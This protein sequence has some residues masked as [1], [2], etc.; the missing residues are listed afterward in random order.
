MS[1]IG[2]AIKSA[3]NSTVARLASQWNARPAVNR[4]P[5][6]LLV[7]IFQQLPTQDRGR[8]ILVSK[9]W[10]HVI[11]SSPSI[12]TT[13]VFKQSEEVVTDPNAAWNVR[14]ICGIDQ[15]L[16]LS[17]TCELRVFVKLDQ[18]NLWSDVFV[19]LR[20]EMHRICALRL[21]IH[22][23]ADEECRHNISELLSRAAPRLRTLYFDNWVA[24]LGAPPPMNAPFVLFSDH[25][26]LLGDVTLQ[27]DVENIGTPCGALRTATNVLI[28]HLGAMDDESIAHMM[29]L[30]PGATDLTLR[31]S[32][33]AARAPL[34]SISG[35]TSLPS[36]VKVLCLYS[37]GDVGAA[38]NVL[39]CVQG[40]QH[41]SQIKMFR[42]SNSEEDSCAAVFHTLVDPVH[43]INGPT[44]TAAIDWYTQASAV[45]PERGPNVYM[46]DID[47]A[48]H[49]LVPYDVH[50]EPAREVYHERVFLELPAPLDPSLFSYVTRLYVGE[51]VFDPNTLYHAVPPMPSLVHLTVMIMSEGY[52][53]HGLISPFIEVSYYSAEATPS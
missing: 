2:D 9:A 34:R 38:L 42:L 27:C 46:F 23:N 33:W 25:A 8:A 1:E 22:G 15:I 37:D 31:L 19:R 11:L 24:R 48:M 53:A 28:S 17:G 6:E 41:L 39:E 36:S 14:S 26:P 45:R 12:W 18:P 50:P 40:W 30:F 16:E 5:L 49:E 4:L 43:S 52:H 7:T 35:R 51:L 13:V 3:V 44:K 10:K 21:V 20:D 29:Q 32:D 47:D